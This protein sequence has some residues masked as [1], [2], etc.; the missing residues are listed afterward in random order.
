LSYIVFLVQRQSRFVESIGVI[1]SAI[2]RESAKRQAQVILDG[3]PDQYV[4]TP[5]T[6]PGER[7][8]FML[9]AQQ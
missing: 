4:V 7:T 8:V 3:D 2:D 9:E 5:I 1:V 6:R